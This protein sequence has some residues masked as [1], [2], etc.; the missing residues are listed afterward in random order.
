VTSSTTTLAGRAGVVTGGGRGIGAGICATLLTAGAGIVDL[1]RSASS[2]PTP[3]R[4]LR[5]QGDA[6]DRGDI[7]QAVRTCVRTYGRI[8]FLV[9]NAGVVTA[10]PFLELTD[11]EWDEVMKVNLTGVFRAIQEASRAMVEAESPGSI[12]VNS[13]INAWWAEPRTAHY[14]ASKAGL[15]GLVRSA[16]RELAPC[17]IRV[18]AIAPGMIQTP[19]TARLTVGSPEAER[20]VGHIPIG[21]YG[22]PSDVGDVTRFLVSDESSFITGTCLT[23]DGGQ[24]LGLDFAIPPAAADA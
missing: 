16:A 22:Q 14:N 24:T 5:L 9:A 20:R 12:V 13:S 11:A 3:E 1:E 17:Q 8:D 21:R 6:G 4:Y 15:L 18:N 10:A 19:L 23:V 2:E 7:N